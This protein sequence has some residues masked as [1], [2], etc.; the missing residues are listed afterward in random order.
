M[1][2]GFLLAAVL[3]VL[4]SGC[5]TVSG[6]H[7]ARRQCLDEPQHVSAWARAR[8]DPCPNLAATSPR[9]GARTNEER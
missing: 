9:I 8:V 6:V 5:T 7:E 1:T 2:A 4:L 3:A